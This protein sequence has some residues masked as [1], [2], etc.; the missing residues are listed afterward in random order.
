MEKSSFAEFLSHFNKIE[1][2]YEVGL[3]DFSGTKKLLE[4]EQVSKKKRRKGVYKEA[5]LIDH[6]YLVEHEL[7]SRMGPTEILPIAR[8]YPNEK[9][10][11]VIYIPYRAIGY[12]GYFNYKLAFFDLQGNVLPA[13]K[14]KN[15][16]STPAFF[17]GGSRMESAITFR[18]DE[19]GR[20]SQDHYEKIWKDDLDEK[21]PIDNE[22]IDYKLTNTKVFQWRP[23][24]GTAIEVRL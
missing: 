4:A 16:R 3:R 14:E 23:E 9:T 19:S 8:F 17:L 24:R 12:S 1:L 13:A 6:L 10:V 11:A 2:G 5:R 18:I 7:Y 22:V 20:I 15:M 21:G